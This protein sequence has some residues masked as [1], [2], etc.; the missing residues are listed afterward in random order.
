M[1]K[2]FAA[3]VLALGSLMGPAIAADYPTQPVRIIH[4]FG[5]GGNADTVA[6][7]LAEPL[8]EALGQPFVVE[9]KPGAGG[10]VASDF[11]AHADPDGYTLQLM[12]GGHSVSGAL[13]QNLSFDAVEDFTFITRITSFPFFIAVRPDTYATIEELIAAGKEGRVKFGS[14]GVGTTQHLTGELLA[15]ET[16]AKMLHIPYKGDAGAVTAL[17]GGEVDMIV[18]AG[19][20]VLSQA[21]SGDLKL[22]AVSWDRPWPTTPDV[23]TVG[24]TVAPGFNVFSWLGLGAPAGLPEE[25]TTVLHDTAVGG[26][27]TP[28]LTGKLEALG[29]LVSPQT[30]QEFHDMVAD[31]VATWNEVI[32]SAGIQRR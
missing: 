1:K 26:L 16:G 29:L 4:G 31:Q 18:S 3:A 13:Y 32:D 30:P 8:T 20:S 6:R 12:V 19:T 28:E 24:D 27:E 10:N 23:P 5:P 11:V 2:T 15:K 7:M 9:P 17:L 25:I 22:L 21:R 14:A